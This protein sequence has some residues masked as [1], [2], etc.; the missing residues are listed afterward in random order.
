MIRKTI[1]G[2]L[3]HR[4]EELGNKKYEHIGFEDEKNKFGEMLASLVPEIGMRKKAKLT[5]Q[6]FDEMEEQ[7]G[8]DKPK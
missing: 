7:N 1:K 5:I 2:E 6:I 3:F 4:I 8:K